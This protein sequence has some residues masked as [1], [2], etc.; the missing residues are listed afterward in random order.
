[1]PKII[2]IALLLLLLSG[3]CLS[4]ETTPAETATDA[5]VR[6]LLEKMNAATGD[7]RD[8]AV[9]E[10]KL[11][12]IG[13]PSVPLLIE[14]IGDKQNKDELR[15]AAAR[16]VVSS[17]PTERLP[18]PPSSLHSRTRMRT[19]MSAAKQPLPWEGSDPTPRTESPFSP[20]CCSTMTSGSLAIRQCH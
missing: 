8:R 14:V 6:A 16:A 5:K 9:A 2:P 1:M 3:A 19:S 18:G 10:E 13:P 15:E 11:L 4:Q 7:R 12:A 20:R 17:G